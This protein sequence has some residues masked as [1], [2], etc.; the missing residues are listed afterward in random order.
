MEI[1]IYQFCPCHSGK[2]IKFCC[3]KD[4]VAD[5]KQIVAK[6]QSNQSLSALEQIDRVMA[7]VGQRDCLL[8]LQTHIYFDMGEVEKARESNRL[9]SSSNPNHP[10]AIQHDALLKL[11]DGDVPGAIDRLQDAMDAIES[12]EIPQ[13]LANAFRLV[14]SVLLAGGHLLAGRAHVQFA[15]LLKDGQDEQL[16]QL[17]MQS[18]RIPNAPLILKSDFRLQNPPADAEWASKY[19]NV[20]RAM[21]R[22]QFRLAL[23]MLQRMDEHWPDQPALLRGVAVV[24]SML[25]NDQTMADSWRRLAR[26]ESLPRWQAVEYEAIALLFDQEEPSGTLPIVSVRCDIKDLDTAF[27]LATVSA[28]LNDGPALEEDPFEEGPAPRHA[29]HVL[30]RDKVDSVEGLAAADIPQVIGD[31]LLYGRQTD[32][33]PRMVFVATKDERFSGATDVIKDQFGDALVGELDERE[34]SETATAT[35]ALT[36]NW[37]VPPDIDMETHRKFVAEQR[38]TVLLEKWPAIEFRCLA[39]RNPVDAS[40]DTLLKL[41]VEALVLNLEQSSALEL[42]DDDVIVALKKKLNIEQQGMLSAKEIDLELVTPLRMRLVDPKTLNDDQITVVFA[43]ATRIS[44]TAV[45]K[46][47][48]PEILERPKLGEAIPRDLCYSMLAQLTDDDEKSME[49]LKVARQEAKNSGG[50]VGALLVQELDIRL[51]RGMTAKLA[52]LLQ[53]IQR[54]HMQEPNIELQLA[55][56]LNKYGLIS[57]DGRTVSLPVPQ[58]AAAAKEGGIW[59]PDSESPAVSAESEGGGGSKIWVPGDA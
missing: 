5:L 6:S 26:L 27:Q 55:R 20:S 3:G 42:S 28:R 30:D 39:G 51:S 18:Y 23:K 15:A 4:I 54:S 17:V 1:D 50:S 41:T 52:E 19:E 14:G 10:I 16:N 2:K 33:E 31:L 9:F 24:N 56:V 11:S 7:K 34:I 36:W 43:E 58:E 38:R 22:G 53:T 44:N 40:S 49:Y 35:H 29:F 25:A 45:L 13:L 59:T 21:N 12:N 57:P 47:V 46:I 37:R 8:A 48:V 32:R